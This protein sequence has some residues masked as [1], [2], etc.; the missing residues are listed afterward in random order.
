MNKDEF[1]HNS[2]WASVSKQFE[3]RLGPVLTAPKRQTGE[4]WG[5]G[6]RG[7]EWVERSV[8]ESLTR[9]T[10]ITLQKKKKGPDLK[11]GIQKS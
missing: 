2:N 9:R 3:E 8:R 4:D 7:R 1:Q 10:M 11:E 6:G 5:P